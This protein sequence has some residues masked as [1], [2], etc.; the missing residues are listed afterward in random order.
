M[1]DFQ[2]K[3]PLFGVTGSFS[4]GSGYVYVY[5]GTLKEKEKYWKLIPYIFQEN[6]YIGTVLRRTWSTENEEVCESFAKRIK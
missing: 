5:L 3:F 2:C 6:I 4:Y 1:Y